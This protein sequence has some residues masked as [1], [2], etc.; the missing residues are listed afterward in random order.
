MQWW[1]NLAAA[2]RGPKYV[3]KT[4]KTP[5]LEGVQRLQA[6]RFHSGHNTA[7]LRDLCDRGYQESTLF[8]AT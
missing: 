3:F 6:A 2:V 5:M 1:L 4:G 7:T 8:M